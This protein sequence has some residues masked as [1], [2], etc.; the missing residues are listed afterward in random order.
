MEAAGACRLIPSPQVW[1]ASA[2]RLLQAALLV[3]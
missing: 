1:Q 2:A 3:V